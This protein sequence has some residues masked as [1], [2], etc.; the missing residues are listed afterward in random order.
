M[1]ARVAYAV[2]SGR[3]FELLIEELSPPADQPFRI[4]TGREW[5][6]IEGVEVSREDWLAAYALETP[7]RR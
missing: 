4:M 7:V 5:W 6:T 1:M 3:R 2:Q